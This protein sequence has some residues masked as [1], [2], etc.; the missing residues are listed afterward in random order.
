M[1]KPAG[2]RKEPARHALSAKGI[3][4]KLVR[5]LK[6]GRLV[7]DQR[8]R[9]Q[10]EEPTLDGLKGLDLQR[11]RSGPGKFEGNFN[12]RLAEALHDATMEGWQDEEAGDVQEVGMWAGYFRDLTEY[13]IKEDGHPVTSAIVQE[14]SNGFFSYATYSD[15]NIAKRDWDG[16]V[17]ELNAAY[18]YAEP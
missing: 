11:E 8:E 5:K 15:K 10:N 17:N 4:T 1:T 6:G 2:W 18:H 16:L 13:N 7:F 9:M 12:A 14:D 3:K